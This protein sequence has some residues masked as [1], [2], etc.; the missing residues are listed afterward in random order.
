MMIIP[1]VSLLFFGCCA[2]TITTVIVTVVVISVFSC[3]IILF[4]VMFV[5]SQG[6][7]EAKSHALAQHFQC[8][9]EGFW[10]V[11]PGREFNA[12]A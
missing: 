4:P 11:W 5:C 3:I 7:P 6:M 8:R 9:V 2:A 1:M 10:G 12:L